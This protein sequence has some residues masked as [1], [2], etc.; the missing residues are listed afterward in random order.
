[1]RQDLEIGPTLGR[2]LLGYMTHVDTCK[3]TSICSTTRTK[4]KM[5]GTYDNK[6]ST[7]EGMYVK[8]YELLNAIDF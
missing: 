5:N 4:C 2:K 1:M 3:L 8:H 7:K 6:S